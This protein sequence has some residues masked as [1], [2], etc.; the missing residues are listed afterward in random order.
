MESQRFDKTYLAEK[1]WK[2][3]HPYLNKQKQLNGLNL[4]TLKQ[5]TKFSKQKSTKPRSMLSFQEG[6]GEMSHKQQNL[7]LTSLQFRK[8]YQCPLRRFAVRFSDA[9]LEKFFPLVQRKLSSGRPIWT[10]GKRKVNLYRDHEKHSREFVWKIITFF[11]TR[12]YFPKIFIYLNLENTLN[13]RLLISF[14]SPLHFE[15]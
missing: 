13:T 9:L 3:F 7:I 2:N 10:F 14:Y 12:K 6:M 4:N 15:H 5:N 1:F 8:N 11:K